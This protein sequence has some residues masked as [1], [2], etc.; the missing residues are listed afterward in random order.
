MLTSCLFCWGLPATWRGTGCGCFILLRYF[1]SCLTNQEE[2]FPGK[3]I[4]RSAV[5]VAIGG[6][7]ALLVSKLLEGEEGAET[8]RGMIEIRREDEFNEAEKQPREHD[9]R[10]R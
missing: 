2:M 5:L 3:D 6:I 7:V 9:E 1:V 4:L 8:Q 10:T